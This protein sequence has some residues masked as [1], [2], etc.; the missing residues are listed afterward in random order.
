[1]TENEFWNH[2]MLRALKLTHYYSTTPVLR[3]VDLTVP[4]GQCVAL[5]GPNGIG[6]TTLLNILGGV[7]SPTFGHVEV[8]GLRRRGTIDEELEIRRQCVFL[9]DDCWLPPDRA[10]ADWLLAVGRVYGVPDERLYSKAS[11]LIEVFNLDDVSLRSLGNC[12]T[13][14]K[15]KWSLCS[16]LLTDAK[17]LLLDE[18]FSGGLDPAGILALQRILRH[19]SARE[20]RTI[21]FTTPVPEIVEGT[22]DRLLVIENGAVAADEMVAELSARSGNGSVTALLQKMFFGTT[23][24]RLESYFAGGSHSVSRN[25]DQTSGEFDV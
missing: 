8:N 12:S 10:G 11:S 6:K 7:L 18:P 2:R 13:G 23:L 5:L 16:A 15:K 21:V 4:D 3:D 25:G 19:A 9:P 24:N 17:I 22:A 1:M 14:Q 20:G